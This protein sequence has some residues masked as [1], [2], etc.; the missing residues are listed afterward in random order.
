MKPQL[1]Q[2]ILQLTLKKKK[3]LFCHKFR[4]IE[5]FTTSAKNFCIIFTPVTQKLT[6]PCLLSH[7]LSLCPLQVSV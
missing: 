4:L 1:S 6:F 3:N 2:G 7:R 5:K